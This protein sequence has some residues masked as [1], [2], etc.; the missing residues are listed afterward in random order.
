MFKILGEKTYDDGEIIF[1]EGETSEDVYQVVSGAVVIVKDVAGRSLI[2]EVLRSGDIFGEMAFISNSPRTATAKAVGDTVIA[3][4]DRTVLE[5]ELASVSPA[6]Q[7]LFECLAMR[8]KKTTDSAAGI[9]MV[10]KDPRVSKT[11][12]VVM[13]H[14]DIQL[15]AYSHNASLGGLYIKTPT[16]LPRGERLSVNLMLPDGHEALH[17]LCEV[18]WS[19]TRTSDPENSPLG[20]GVKFL[21]MSREDYDR[22]KRALAVE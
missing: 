8:L 11:W 2:V 16:P 21:N 18:A 12:F 19:R 15:S 14:G 4:V 10:R 5:D 6:L 13:E 17:I 22:L 3:V 1:H 7:V 20:M 9:T